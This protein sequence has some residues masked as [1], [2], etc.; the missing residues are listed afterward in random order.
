M[1]NFK[2]KEQLSEQQKDI[3]KQV[4]LFYEIYNDVFIKFSNSNEKREIIKKIYGI[5][6]Y[7]NLPKL[8]STLESKVQDGIS[9]YRGISA[10]SIDKL[11]GYVN[12]FINGDVFYGG[13]ASI[14][15]TGIYT[16]MGENLSVASKYA[17]DGGINSCGIVIESKLQ[18]DSKIIKNTEINEIRNFIFEKIRRMYKSEIEQFLL[19][20]EDDG[21]LAAILGYDAIYVEEKNYMV[22]LNRE[23]MIV[24]DI[25]IVNK[26]NLSDDV[27]NKH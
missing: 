21:A 13:R 15:G 5:L 8:Y 27:K 25:D 20:L 18:K 22:V 16:V 19:I 26:L 17:S 12:E 2:K 23:K 14:Y 7:G 4:S 24:N 10:D 3:I 11:K 9:I 6:H 1:F